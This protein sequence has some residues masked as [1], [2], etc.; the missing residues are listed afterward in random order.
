MSQA[1]AQIEKCLNEYKAKPLLP[2]ELASFK[3]ILDKH[4]TSIESLKPLYTRDPV[5]C[6]TVL[7][8]AFKLTRQRP[9]QPFAVDHALATIGIGGINRALQPYYRLET[10][11]LSDEVKLSLSSSLLA[12]ELAKRLGDES[13]G[14]PQTQWTAMFYQLPETILWYIQ[15]RAMW[16]I[17]YRRLTLPKKLSLF[18]ESKLGFNLYDWRKAVAQEFHMSE[19]I[20]GLYERKLPEIPKELLLYSK[21]GYG[22][23]TP[24]LK[25]WD[26]DE[27]WLVVLCNRLAR[28]IYT[29]WPKKSYQ[30]TFKLIS[31]L[32]MIEHKPLKSIIDQSVLAIART[33]KYCD[34]FNPGVALLMIPD[35]PIYP[36]WLVGNEHLNKNI[37]QRKQQVNS[38]QINKK[39]NDLNEDCKNLLSNALE[40]NNSAEFISNGVKLAITRLGFDRVSFLSVDQKSKIVETKFSLASKG[41]EKIRPDFSFKQPTPLAKFTEQQAFKHLNKNDNGKIW[42][43]LP[44]AIRKQ[45]VESFVLFSVKPGKQIRALIYLD[46]KDPDVFREDNLKQTKQLLIAINKG[47]ALRNQQKVKSR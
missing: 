14:K 18:E 7:E 44:Q 35:K 39:T 36:D 32:L 34:L 5:F 23:E 25:G 40:F 28:A 43:K 2:L 42:P 17:Y 13:L 24:S 41:N 37:E 9:S 3:R 10:P 8:A 21:N 38:N 6:W 46:A 19:Y 20:Q 45:E 31:R 26:R 1:N 29:P 15:P 22:E 30:N 4:D 47:L 11:L 33:L 27:G 16:H 12:A